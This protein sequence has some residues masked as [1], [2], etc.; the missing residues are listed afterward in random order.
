M[1][2]KTIIGLAA[3]NQ[4]PVT[5]HTVCD[6]TALTP[7]FTIGMGAT[8]T[9]PKTYTNIPAGSKCTAT[10][11]VDGSTSTVGVT[12]SGSG[13]QVTI[14][15]GSS[16]TTTITD[17]Y[18]FL[19]GSLTV[20]KVIAGDGAGSQGPIT[21]QAVCNG[22]LLGEWTITQN[23]AAGT[24]P[25]TW[26]GIAANSSCVVTETANGSNSTVG[27]ATV[28]SG[29]TVTV[30][31]GQ[32]AQ[33]TITD[34]YTFL[35]G[36]LTVTK[37]IAGAAAGQQGQVTIKVSCDGT[38]LS[39][40][41][42]VDAKAPAGDHSETY[43]G[44]RAGSTCS[45]TETADGSTSTVDVA[46]SGDNGTS[47]TVPAGGIATRHITDTYTHATG[48]LVV[49]KLIAG[50]AAGYQ[51]QVTITVNCG[52]PRWL[53]LS[54]RQARRSPSRRLTTTSRPARPAPLTRP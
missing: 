48:S 18:S 44:I 37:S 32:N 28:G 17:N 33:A 41:L 54:S 43:T 6:G 1:V 46:I 42:T 23:M 47:V 50:P 22:T 10:E 34:T 36:S 19:P 45:A 24:Y 52:G 15:S 38:E 21:I 12:V 4:G 29:Q 20:N 25:H 8:S 9:P 5:I 49:S 7:D 27:V 53:T 14:P 3:G 31:A 26:S 2:Q 35:S 16:V 11:T 51:S 40:E 30:G 39:P 13:Q